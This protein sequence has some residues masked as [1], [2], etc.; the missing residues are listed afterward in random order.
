MR[1]Y[2]L[3]CHTVYRGSYD[4]YDAAVNAAEAMGV[5]TYDIVVVWAKP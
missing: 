1:R 5:Y 4:T 3:Y 2:E